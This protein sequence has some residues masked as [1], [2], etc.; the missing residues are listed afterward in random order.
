MSDSLSLPEKLRCPGCGDNLGADSASRLDCA[1]CS[2]TYPV[3]DGI[4]W[5]YRDV[6]SSR[7][8]WAGKLQ[9]LRDEL[10]SEMASLDGLLA[11][12]DLMATT[13]E[14]IARLRA[15]TERLGT[16]IFELLA[17]FAFASSE[18]EERLPRDRIP[19]KQHFSSYLETVYRDWCW[20]EGEIE[21]ARELIE[22]LLGGGP[23]QR[24]ALVLGGGAGRLSY[25]IARLG[26]WGSVVQ[27]DI[28]P[29]LTRIGAL[30][31]RGE[32]VGLT[33]IP[34][35]PL[36]LEHVAVDQTLS[37]PP[38]R[39]DGPL[40]FLLGD[41]FAP[42]FE[43]GSFDLLVTPWF[44][45][46]L[47]ESFDR[48]ARRLSRLLAPGGRWINFGPL[49]F[50]SL[51]L[52][53]RFTPEEMVEALAGAGMVVES[54]EL[55]RVAYLHSP[56]GMSRRHE[57]IFVFAATRGQEV[58]RAPDF[59]F[60]PE[61]M[62]RPGASVPALPDFEAMRNDRVFDLEILGL[63]DG[64]RSIDE[65]V[66][67]LSQR[68]SLAEDRCRNAV[69]RFFSKWFEAESDPGAAPRG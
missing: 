19:S 12:D 28:N 4:P 49:S 45:D 55:R 2:S 13:A 9:L 18:V 67:T 7:A 22:P 30:L 46:I 23:G 43:A 33:E 60:Y 14:R 65:I 69:H 29:L 32:N 37:P 31:A 53:E 57:E 58:E 34:R 10:T 38:G 41:A 36:G 16:R 42:P 40:H 62:T 68:Y 52:S 61:W 54:S 66:S 56:H 25:E 15:G 44:V 5:L 63:I 11:R 27:L 8:Q 6:A 47:P 59:T 21:A 24:H 39:P 35:L 3:F 50:E 20:G 64:R 26:S 48:L 1:G 51:P 17:P